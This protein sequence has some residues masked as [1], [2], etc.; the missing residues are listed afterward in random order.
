M[1]DVS[2]GPGWWQAADLKWYPPELHA[3]Y[4]EPTPPDEQPQQPSDSN[5]AAT[6]Q[7]RPGWP[8]VPQS[9]PADRPLRQIDTPPPPSGQRPRRRPKW[10]LIAAIIVITI[11]AGI[12]T[13]YVGAPVIVAKFGP[14]IDVVTIVVLILSYRAKV[15][16][17]A[18][19]K[20]AAVLVAGWVIG[21][22][23]SWGLVEVFPRSL[24]SE[25][26][27]LYA[28]N[29]VLGLRLADPETFTGRPPAVFDA[30]FTLFGALAL[31]VAV[32]VLSQSLVQAESRAQ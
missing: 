21:I 2:Q 31:I 23:M 32:I 7:R 28:A 14:V 17:S 1:S 4:E 12:T 20:A 8:L 11:V 25:C 29:R 27:L 5:L 24:A 18:L 10:P 9:R 15:R 16:P 6:Q 26:R 3:D 19:V 22:L 13:G 30:L